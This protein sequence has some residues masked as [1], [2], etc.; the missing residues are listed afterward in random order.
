MNTARM[1]VAACAGLGL[2]SPASGQSVPSYGLDFVTIG[3]AGNR[4]TNAK[5]APGLAN[6]PIGDVD[7]TYRIARTEVTVGQWL[8]FANAYAPYFNGHDIFQLTGLLTRPTGNPPGQGPAYEPRHPGSENW[9]AD[10]GWRYAARYAN[11]LHNGKVKDAWAFE[12]GAY[13]TS[14]FKGTLGRN[15]QARRSPGAR[16]WIPDW[17]EW[18]KAAYYD[19]DRYA[20]GEEGYWLYPDLSQDELVGGLPGEPG[21]QTNANLFPAPVGMDVGSYPGTPSPWGLLDLSGGQRE[22]TETALGSHNGR[23]VV[24]G[25]QIGDASSPDDRID[26]YYQFSTPLPAGL[27]IASIPSPG[28]IC[29][30]ACAA[31]GFIANRRRR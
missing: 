13:D 7:Y 29:I 22:W 31:L 3:A 11:W 30:L 1:L 18:T 8:E 16:F 25:S 2:A 23:R 6:S 19:P 26:W 27:R 28:G 20:P 9:P 24:V 21:A 17:D 14:T 15:D 5:E 12:S 10:M 4:P